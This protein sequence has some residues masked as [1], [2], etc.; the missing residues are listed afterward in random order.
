MC[1]GVTILIGG[2]LFI[3]ERHTIFGMDFTGGYS[4]TVEVQPDSQDNYRA[5]IEEALIAGGATPQ[6]FQ[7]RELTP[8]NNIRIFLSKGMQQ[9]GKPFYGMPVMYDLK[10]YSYLYQLNPRINWVVQT[11]EK[12][13]LKMAPSTL[14]ELDQNWSEVSGQL[15]DSMKKSAGIGLII[16]LLCILFYITVR[17]EFKYAA[18]AII[19]LAHS[20]F[21]SLGMIAILHALKLPLQID[22]NTVA[23]LMTI[24]GYSLNDTIIIFDRIREDVRLMRKSTFEEIVTHALNATL[25]RTM[26]TSGITLL[27]LL[28][29]VCLGG[30]TI[31]TFAFMMIIGVI[32]GTLSSLFVAAP[33]M[34]YFHNKQQEKNKNSLPQVIV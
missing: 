31:F 33:L 24:V 10:D 2:F 8:S 6:N 29:L 5:R 1:T 28:P 4:L 18:S 15:S 27:A 16:A 21:I 9:P 34:V 7:I 3:K 26:M 13:Q 23:A 11:L 17:F 14:N 19:S 22:L 30:S 12:G 25:T 20:V 32:F